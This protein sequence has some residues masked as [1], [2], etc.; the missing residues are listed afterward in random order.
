MTLRLNRFRV[1][2]LL[3][4]PSPI[5]KFTFVRSIPNLTCD[6]RC[7]ITL[8]CSS[9]DSPSPSSSRSSGGSKRSRKT[10]LLL[11]YSKHSKT[12]WTELAYILAVKKVL[13]I[14]LRLLNTIQRRSISKETVDKLFSLST[15]SYRYDHTYTDTISQRL[16]SESS[17]SPLTSIVCPIRHGRIE[18]LRR[19]RAFQTASCATP[20]QDCSRPWRTKE[21]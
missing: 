9:T 16:L 1:W 14:K 21:E 12:D 5:S 2:G 17:C 20:C 13:F 7:L 18:G 11:F 10:K 4:L 15:S 8:L 3:S 6:K 19:I